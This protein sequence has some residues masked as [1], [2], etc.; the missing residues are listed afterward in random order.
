MRLCDKDINTVACPSPSGERVASLLTPGEGVRDTHNP[1]I[2]AGLWRGI[3]QKE[4]GR[5][6]LCHA[7][8]RPVPRAG[9]GHPL[10]SNAE[11]TIPG[12]PVCRTPSPGVSTRHPLPEGEGR[13]LLGFTLLEVLVA[14]VIVSM[15]A[16]GL[17]VSDSTWRVKARQAA[18]EGLSTVRGGRV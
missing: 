10:P 9:R 12:S 17:A 8:T 1:R 18:T 6:F 11:F 13:R 15:I 14:M 16:A 5:L 3:F 4:I 2:H 7:L